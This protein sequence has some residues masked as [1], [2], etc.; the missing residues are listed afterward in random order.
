MCS[1][2][3]ASARRYPGDR[4]FGYQEQRLLAEHRVAWI[5]WLPHA[6]PP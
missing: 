5:G 6:P 1:K 4:K 3:R 2:E